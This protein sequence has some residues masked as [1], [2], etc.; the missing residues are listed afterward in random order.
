MNGTTD[1][2][3]A[4]GKGDVGS[5]GARFDGDDFSV[6]GAYRIGS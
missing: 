3:E 2:I 5:G 6:F 1:Y 4:Y